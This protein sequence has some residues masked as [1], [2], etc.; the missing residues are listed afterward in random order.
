LLG[1]EHYT[2]YINANPWRG[3]PHTFT[4][5]HEGIMHPTEQAVRKLTVDVKGKPM[6]VENMYK[7]VAFP[8]DLIDAS[9]LKKLK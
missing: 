3:K 1:G 2:T 8:D 7:M 6:T 9:I 4:G 5:M